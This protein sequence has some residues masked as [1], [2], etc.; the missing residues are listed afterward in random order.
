VQC[1]CGEQKAYEV[2]K[3]AITTM[4]VEELDRYADHLAD[5]A[6]TIT[7][8]IEEA[9]DLNMDFIAEIRGE[10]NPDLTAA[11]V[12]AIAYKIREGEDVAD[13]VARLVNRAYNTA[14]AL[15]EIANTLQAE[16]DA[17]KLAE[18]N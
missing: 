9:S 15:L 2:E 4:T 3:M 6:R 16:S 5:Q 8:V 10:V 1:A 7:A 14:N 13:T 18:L 11:V 12:D 17:K